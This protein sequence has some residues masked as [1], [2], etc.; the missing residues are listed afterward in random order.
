MYSRTAL[1]IV[2]S[3]CVLALLGDAAYDGWFPAGRFSDPS[4]RFCCTGGSCCFH[5][6]ENESLLHFLA[7]VELFAPPISPL[8]P[9][10]FVWCTVVITSH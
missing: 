4:G 5:G 7:A 3:V 10:S 6:V 8:C 1:A 9:W 2:Y